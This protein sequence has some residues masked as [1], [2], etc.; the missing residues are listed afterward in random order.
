MSSQAQKFH[1]RTLMLN[2]V[3]KPGITYG[4][5]AELA[6]DKW[7]AYASAPP[8]NPSVTWCRWRAE[9]LD[10]LSDAELADLVLQLT[11][12]RRIGLHARDDPP[13]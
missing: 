3:Y 11:Q 9:A 12:A 2:L 6:K 1:Y 13:I 4:Q 8:D 10:A 5:L 7:D